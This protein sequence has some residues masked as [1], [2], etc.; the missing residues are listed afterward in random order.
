MSRKI[1]SRKGYIDDLLLTALIIEL[2]VI[3]ECVQYPT[4]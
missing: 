3:C 2:T 1:R 4:K